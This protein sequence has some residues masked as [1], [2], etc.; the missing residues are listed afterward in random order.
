MFP[1]SGQVTGAISTAA[2]NFIVHE[3]TSRII[4]II[5]NNCIIITIIIIIINI[6]IIITIFSPREI[7]D[8]L[9]DR[10]FCSRD[11]IYLK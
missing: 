9:S 6:C 11:F 8:Q 2:F 4:I 1:T 3:P 7:I 10:S 5:I